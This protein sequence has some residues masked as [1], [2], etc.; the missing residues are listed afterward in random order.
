MNDGW[1]LASA[2]IAI[3]NLAVVLVLI[4]VY[5]FKSRHYKAPPLPRAKF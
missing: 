2:V 4:A 5:L 1:F 3:I